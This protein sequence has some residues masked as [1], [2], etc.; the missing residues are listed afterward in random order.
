MFLQVFLVFRDSSR[1]KTGCGSS[2]VEGNFC[3]PGTVLEARD[4]M[5]KTALVPALVEGDHIVL[6]KQS[7]LRK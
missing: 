2:A 6:A 1:D 7:K 5:A 3:V 4:T